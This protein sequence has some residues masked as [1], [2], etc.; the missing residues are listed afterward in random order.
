[1]EMS[2]RHPSPPTDNVELSI[3]VP[4]LNEGAHISQLLNSLRS[5]STDKFEVIVVDG[6]SQDGTTKIAES[7]GARVFALEGAKEFEARNYAV[8][9]SKAPILVF[10]CADVV[11]PPASLRSVLRHFQDDSDL[12]ALTGPDVPYD[13]GPNLRLAYG[14][15]NTLRFLFSRLPPPLKAFSS[16]TNFLAVRRDA[17]QASGGFKTDDVNADG[18][19]GRY[20]ASRH[21]ILFDNGVTVFI[22]A[23]RATNWGISRFTRHYLYV[24]ENFLPGISRKQWFRS[25]KSRSSKSHGEI[26]GEHPASS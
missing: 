8:A 11:F 12:V 25:L 26:H 24:L 22:S 9:L 18:L 5:Q 20:L 6:G 17:F 3:I 4:T 1:M 14:I 15:Y 19:M 13:G 21:R 23:R 2:S 16:S 10:S 7:M